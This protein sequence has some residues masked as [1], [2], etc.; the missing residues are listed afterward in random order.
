MVRSPDPFSATTKKNGKKQ[1]GYARLGV[2]V[3]R[4][5]SVLEVSGRI[6]NNAFKRRLAFG[7]TV[8][9]SALNNFLLLFSTY[10]WSIMPFKSLTDNLYALLCI[11]SCSHES[12]DFII[13]L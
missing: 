10:V 8:I 7:F 4:S 3:S 5:V 1:S 12:F 11:S 13:Y 9:I 2:A 6:C